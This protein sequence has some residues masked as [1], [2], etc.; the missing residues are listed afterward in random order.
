[1]SY[2]SFRRRD[3]DVAAA[4]A[5]VA[6]RPVHVLDARLRPN[7][8]AG[9]NRAY[10]IGHGEHRRIAALSFERGGEAVVAEFGVRRLY[11]VG[12]PRQRAGVARGDEMRIVDLETRRQIIGDDDSAELRLGFGNLEHHHEPRVL[13]ELCRIDRIAV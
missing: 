9:R 2:A 6:V 7:I 11:R 5:A 10:Y 1:F 3:L 13:L 4:G 12:D 8:S